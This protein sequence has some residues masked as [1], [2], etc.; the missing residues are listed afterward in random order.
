MDRRVV[1]MSCPWSP[2]HLPVSPWQKFYTSS[3]LPALGC[4]PSLRLLLVPFVTFPDIMASRPAVGS[5]LLSEEPLFPFSMCCGW[6]GLDNGMVRSYSAAY[7]TA[8]ISALGG[9][10]G[11][12][13]GIRR[14]RR[15]LRIRRRFLLYWAAAAAGEEGKSWTG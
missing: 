10:R 11:G 3:P 9:R 13:L 2:L 6:P 7:C 15:W 5:M 14:R 1:I 12:R 8:A 4:L